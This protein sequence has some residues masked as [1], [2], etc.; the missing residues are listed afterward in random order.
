MCNKETYRCERNIYL[1]TLDSADW[2]EDFSSSATIR[3]GDAVD[4]AGFITI[5]VG[6]SGSGDG[7]DL[8]LLAGD[9]DPANGALG[10]GGDVIIQS[11]SSST[12][13]SGG[14]SISTDA[15][16]SSGGISMQTGKASGGDSGTI[17]ITSGD[18]TNSA[19]GI[20]IQVGT[21]GDGDGG[22]LILSAGDVDIVESRAMGDGGDVIMESGSSATGSSGS[23]S[24]RSDAS[25]ASG[26]VSVETGDASTGDS[27]AIE[28]TTGDA[29]QSSGGISLSA[30]AATSGS[31]GNIEI[32]GGETASANE[33]GGGVNIF[34]GDAPN[35]DGGFVF[36]QGGSGKAGGS[37]FVNGGGPDGRVIIGPTTE[38]IN[39]GNQDAEIAV[40]GAV[41]LDGSLTFPGDTGVTLFGI[42]KGS[43]ELTPIAA[44]ETLTIEVPVPGTFSGDIA[45]CS[46]TPSDA[47]VGFNYIQV[48]DGQVTVQA[49]NYGDQDEITVTCLVHDLK[50]NYL[51]QCDPSSPQVGGNFDLIPGT[52]PF[53][54]A[55]IQRLEAGISAELPEPT[56]NATL[57][58]PFLPL[59]NN[60]AAGDQDRSVCTNDVPYTPGPE[61]VPS[62]CR[63]FLAFSVDP[64]TLEVTYGQC[65][66]TFI[67][68]KDG[69]LMFWT[70]AHCAVDD[71]NNPF[72]LTSP[73]RPNQ[74]LSFVQCDQ[75]RGTEPFFDF[76]GPGYFSVVGGAIDG[77]FD[78]TN[79]DNT[80]VYDGTLLLVSPLADTDLKFAEPFY[81]AAITSSGLGITR[82]NY[83]GGFPAEDNRLVGCSSPPLAPGIGKLLFYSRDEVQ[84]Q[85]SGVQGIFVN[86]FSGCG[87]NSGGPILAEDACVTYGSLSAASIGCNANSESYLVYSRIV[88]SS[89]TDPGVDL[90]ALISN[91]AVGNV[92]VV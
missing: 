37:V 19:G 30:G 10:D 6:T 76:Q 14:V 32:F 50:P 2:D 56:Y 21:S 13:S 17:D 49:R 8:T 46:V 69:A 70:A 63:L 53:N 64:V 42:Y 66:G 79:F 1:Y 51:P 59:I 61:A 3:T 28:L 25:K 86:G 65:S 73:L 74:Y 89:S 84:V 27:G 9:V 26:S 5:E 54:L 43:S 40:T 71:N 75:R 52:G 90:G 11:G 16:V 20:T 18:A 60:T 57:L 67:G 68:A 39:I 15:S 58:P 31:G 23:V 72:L 44:D 80:N 78:S 85:S 34:G 47:Q 82:S 87:G 29:G 81:A 33:R 45:T 92:I 62:V 77:Q 88:T 36:I 12:A 55:D 7:S 41:T 22:D 4:T 24:I 38:Q 48:G 83:N 35:S 91:I